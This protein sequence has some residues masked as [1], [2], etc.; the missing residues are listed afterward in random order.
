LT[1]KP[2]RREN[3]MEKRGQS[4]LEYLM[5]Y[6][7]ALIVIAIV[8]GVL[9]YVTSTGTGGVTCQS[10]SQALIVKEWAV[11][12]GEDGVG[13]TLQNATGNTINIDTNG[14]AAVGDFSDTAGNASVSPSSVP[15]NNTFT[16]T[17]VDANSAGT[18]FNDGRVMVSYT[19][20]GGLTASGVITCA[21]TV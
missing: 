7:W 15:K 18:T 8:I 5:T 21:G 10:T 2:K 20:S 12:A 3:G 11:S 13:L 14:I 1:K 4:A 6:G 19:T 9:I 16:V 17:N